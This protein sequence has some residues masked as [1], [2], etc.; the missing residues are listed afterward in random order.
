MFLACRPER[1]YEN[2]PSFRWFVDQ[3]DLQCRWLIPIA[4]RFRPVYG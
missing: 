1:I 4:D 3:L 2:S